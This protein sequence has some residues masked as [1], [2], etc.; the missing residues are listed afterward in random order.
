MLVKFTDPKIYLQGTCSAVCID[1]TTGNVDYYSDKFST[2]SITTSNSE[3]VIRS[4]LGNTIAAIIPTECDVSV[5]FT[6]DNFSLWAKAANTGA[7][8]S[9]G[10]PVMRCQTVTATSTVLKVDTSSGTPVAGLA[11]PTAQ[12][13]VQTVGSA[14]PIA[15]TGNAYDIEQDGTV[16]GFTA[17]SGSTYKVYYYTS[18]ANARV[19]AVMNQFDP[20]IEYFVAQIAGYRNVNAKKKGGTRAGWLYA[21]VP[22]L[23]FGGADGG[24]TGSQTEH[25]T[26][27]IVGRALAPEDQIVSGECDDC[28]GSNSTA[29]YVWVDD[30]PTVGINGLVLTG[31]VVTV[32]KGGKAKAEFNLAMAD[33][34]LV[35]PDPARMSYEMT[36]P[37]TGVTVDASGVLTATESATGEG[38]LTG[39]YTDGSATFTLPVIVSVGS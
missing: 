26:T 5:E 24:I 33:F 23:K 31:G 18:I 13:Y 20:R 22:S 19:A 21:I 17:V 7:R 12:A 36:T 11:R 37:V 15:S 8:L 6:A 25:D 35:V 28:G 1:P 38:E 32:P 34:S 10:A 30:D 4:G 2:S 39:T 3:G 16:V 9:Y 29:Y 14:A 27:K